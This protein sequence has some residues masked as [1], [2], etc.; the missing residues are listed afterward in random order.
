MTKIQ[1]FT[2]I[3]PVLP[4]IQNAYLNG[5]HRIESF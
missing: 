3:E 5:S 4:E 2:G 1:I